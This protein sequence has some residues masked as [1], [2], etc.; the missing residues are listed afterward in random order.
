MYF[1]FFL[2]IKCFVLT[3]IIKSPLLIISDKAVT[4]I[5]FPYQVYPSILIISQNA[6]FTLLNHN[7]KYNLNSTKLNITI[8][9]Q[10]IICEKN[11]DLVSIDSINFNFEYYTIIKRSK[12]N[13]I[14]NA[15]ALS[16]NNNENK[17][18]LSQLKNNKII[19]KK[20]YGFEYELTEEKQGN[21]Y[22]GEIPK[23]LTMRKYKVKCPIIINNK[24]ERWGCKINKLYFEN[25]EYKTFDN[26]LITFGIERSKM[27]IPKKI[28]LF[29][30]E[31]VFIKY[32]KS[33]DCFYKNILSRKTIFCNENII[34]KLPKI[35]FEFLNFSLIF[36]LDILF[37]TTIKKNNSNFFLKLNIEI[38]NEDENE[39]VLGWKF[40]K[41]YITKFDYDKGIITFYNNEPFLSIKLKQIHIQINFYLKILLYLMV[42]SILF[43]LFII[44]KFKI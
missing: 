1:L 25:F 24:T 20:I 23:I 38:N 39:W 42:L 9:N 8:K 32:Y 21:F 5:K 13:F 15:L 43:E 35:N 28:L 31:T 11:K 12:M 40:L 37:V 27:K 17:D 6:K 33:G 4:N 16:Y 2:Y 30:N 7:K 22:I 14:N 29:I 34:N 26:E 19:Q 18:F 41:S 3:V 36:N 10:S 44:I